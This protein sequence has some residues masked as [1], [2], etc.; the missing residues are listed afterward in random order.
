MG[1]LSIVIPCFNDS[2]Y[3]E[4]AVNSAL[5]QTYLQK[6]VIVVDDG[7]NLETKAVLANIKPFI[8]RLISQENLG[9]VAARNRGIREAQ[10]EYI[11]TLDADDYFEPFFLEKACEILEKEP[12]VGMVTCW[13]NI[14]DE[15]G[16]QMRIAKPSGAAA[17]N[18]IYYNNAPGSLLFRKQ[19]WEEV[20]GYDKQLDNGNEDWEFNVSITK[21]GW[22]VHVIPEILFNYRLKQS[23]RNTKAL[24]YRKKMR[25][26]AFKKHKDLLIAD[27]DKTIDFFLKEIE[28]KENENSKLRSSLSYRLG[29]L[30][31]KPL[32]WVK[33]LF[34]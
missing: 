30:L 15:K 21:K 16:D 13:I 32:R 5:A 23:S 18:A 17:Q 19:C 24:E 11:L 28:N 8:D 10:G 2:N 33:S 12:Q 9:V 34:S 25:E 29:E 6:E 7:S 3:I 27:I 4:Q 22:K 31:L 1:K 20:D 14:V 26:Y